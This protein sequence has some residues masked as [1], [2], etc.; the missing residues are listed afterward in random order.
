MLPDMMNKLVNSYLPLFHVSLF[1]KTT[2][3][4]LDVNQ[5]SYFIGLPII[6]Y[7]NPLRS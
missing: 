7:C 6:N 2:L 4:Q 1:S 3:L 5:Y